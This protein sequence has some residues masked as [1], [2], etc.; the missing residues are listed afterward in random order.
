MRIISLL[1]KLLDKLQLQ[2]PEQTN[3]KSI[4]ENLIVS[5]CLLKEVVLKK[6]VQF[7]GVFAKMSRPIPGL[8]LFGVK[9]DSPCLWEAI[10]LCQNDEQFCLAYTAV[11]G[12]GPTCNGGSREFGEWADFIIEQVAWPVLFPR[13]QTAV[14]SI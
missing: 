10:L 4:I 7:S 2:E 5:R 8:A 3:K 11:H 6:C 9:M 1:K 14:P 13:P 12:L